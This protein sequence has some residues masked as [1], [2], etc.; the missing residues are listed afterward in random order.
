MNPREKISSIEFTIKNNLCDL[1]GYCSDEEA[2]YLVG[3]EPRE[4][5]FEISV[6]KEANC[7]LFLFLIPQFYFLSSHV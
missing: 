3:I 7:A 6:N 5:P 1:I 2:V 4:V